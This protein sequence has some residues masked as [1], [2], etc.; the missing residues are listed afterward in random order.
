MG[1][2]VERESCRDCK[3]PPADFHVLLTTKPK[4]FGK[5]GRETALENYRHIH[6]RL[7]CKI[8]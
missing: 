6:G 4:E 5:T 2:R 7:R 1:K 3:T 8:L